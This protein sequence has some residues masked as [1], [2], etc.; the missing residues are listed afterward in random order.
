MILNS[1]IYFNRNI[2]ASFL[3]G[4]IKQ[5]KNYACIFLM[6]MG[7]LKKKQTNIE[8]HKSVV[9]DTKPF[10]ANFFYLFFLYLLNFSTFTS[11]CR[12]LWVIHI[13]R[14]SEITVSSRVNTSS[15]LSL[16][17]VHSKRHYLRLSE[18]IRKFHKCEKN[19]FFRVDLFVF[20][21]F[22]FMRL[23]FNCLCDLVKIGH[24]FCSF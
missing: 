13:L 3:T 14:W 24:I 8:D 18:T 21:Y 22:F 10:G 2:L 19:I 6:L 20:I 4:K 7:Q 1:N 9:S 23:Y 5:Q 16:Y 17:F 15:S 12:P 11:F